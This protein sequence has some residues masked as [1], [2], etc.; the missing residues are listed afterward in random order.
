MCIVYNELRIGDLL[1]TLQQIIGG[2]RAREG[3]EPET[4]GV[5]SEN[6]TNTG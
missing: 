3:S 2:P 5:P 1:A 4:F 6:A